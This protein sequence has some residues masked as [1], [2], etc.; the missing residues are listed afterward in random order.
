MSGITG[1]VVGGASGA[2]AAGAI[3]S[4]VAGAAGTAVAPGVGTA[5]GIAGGFIGGAAGATASNAI[6]DILH[7]GDAA[8]IGR[9]LNAYVSYMSIEYML[10]ETELGYLTEELD[11]ITS[12]E[13]NE[14]FASFLQSEEQENALREFLTPRFET[15][16]AKREPFKLP[17][18][19]SIDDALS[20]ILVSI[21]E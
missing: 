8:N 15:V 5:I 11:K 12:D 1:S 14:L 20:E 18:Q 3:A 17:D 16:I 2:I 4:K 9:L 6:G 13:F 21:T 10:N 19:S 7:E